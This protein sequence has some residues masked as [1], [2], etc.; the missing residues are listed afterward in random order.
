MQEKTIAPHI[1][2]IA[3]FLGPYRNLT[4]LVASLMASHPRC[5]VLNH[6]FDRLLADTSLDFFS[7]GS[8]HLFLESA[9]QHIRSG[10][11]GSFGG[12]IRLS[13]AFEDEAI[14]RLYDKYRGHHLILTEAKCFIWKDSM[15]ITNHIAS[16]GRTPQEVAQK[17]PRIRFILPIRNPL[18][19]A[20]ANLA[21][22][23]R[24]LIDDKHPS[25]R[26]VL[27]RILAIVREI[28]KNAA[29]SPSKFFVFSQPEL[30][31]QEFWPRL[32]EFLEVDYPDNW[33]FD[34][35]NAVNLRSGYKHT[36]DEI[37][38]YRK[39]V[40]TMFNDFPETRERLLALA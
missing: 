8:V 1:E 4:T 24:F 39:L 34:V 19:C 7:G 23:F 15:R 16:L 9:V 38:A 36:T 17:D 22:K 3:I 26:K 14:R 5:L 25:K 27:R 20:Q 13:H 6:A 37:E 21:N 2:T 40:R 11:R 10:K 32:C 29:M 31:N 18:D 28:T 33:C 35:V 30:K 12:D